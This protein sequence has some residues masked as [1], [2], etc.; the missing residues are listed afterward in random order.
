MLSIRGALP[1][2]VVLHIE[3]GDAY[4]LVEGEARRRVSVGSGETR[5]VWDLRGG[6]HW[7]DLTV[8]LAGDPSYR[9]RLAGHIET[10]RA[11][12][13]DPAIGPMRL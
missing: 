13:T 8:A 6:D 10:G 4:P 1:R 11:S 2:R 7:Y 5:E 12:R 9:L 3:M